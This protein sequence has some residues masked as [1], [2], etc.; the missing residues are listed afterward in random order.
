MYNINNRERYGGGVQ[1]VR[2]VFYML[3]LTTVSLI[4]GHGGWAE[5]NNI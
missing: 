5:R 3:I 2:E 1:L 4:Q